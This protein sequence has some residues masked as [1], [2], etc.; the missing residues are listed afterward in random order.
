MKDKTVLDISIILYL[1]ILGNQIKHLKNHQ[2]SKTLLEGPK[3]SNNFIT[4]PEHP[5]QDRFPYKV[6]WRDSQIDQLAGKVPG[7]YH[8]SL[9]LYLHVLLISAM[10][11][12]KNRKYNVQV[13][14]VNIFAVT[15]KKVKSSQE[16]KRD[17]LWLL[18]QS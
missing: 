2:R 14:V 3:I 1:C 5:G 12:T 8:S 18:P 16:K 15:A 11:K 10:I 7:P 13:K 17:L 6:W 9:S 4:I